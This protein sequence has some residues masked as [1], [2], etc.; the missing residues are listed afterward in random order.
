MNGAFNAKGNEYELYDA[1][2]KFPLYNYHFNREYYA[3][4]ANDLSG[5]ST[6]FYTEKK[7]FTRGERFFLIKDGES[8]W[9]VGGLGEGGETVDER[10]TVYKLHSTLLT[11]KRGGIVATA[12]GFVPLE[13][14]REFFIYTVKNEST[15]PKRIS[16]I[17]ACALEGGPMSSECLAEEGGR[18]ISVMTVPYHIYYEDYEKA[19]K[20]HNTCYC[21][22]SVQPSRV[23]CNE[24]VLF[25]GKRRYVKN[26]FD[27]PERTASYNGEH[28]GT[29]RYDAELQ[30]GESFTFSTVVGICISREDARKNVADFLSGKER[31]EDELKKA[32]AFFKRYASKKKTAAK[33]ENIDNFASFWQVKQV[34]CM[35]MTKRLSQT[36]S[37]RNSLQDAMGVGYV[38]REMAR[39]YFVECLKLQKSDGSILQHG[40]WNDLFPPR[41]LGLLYMKDGP[42]W[43]VICLSNYIYD[44]G[45]YDFLKQIVAFKDGGEDT[46]EG[47]LLR[48]VDFMWK[49]RGTYGLS[50]LG[51]GDWT[52]P[53]NGPGRKGKGVSTWTSMAFVYGMRTLAKVLKHEEKN[54]ERI[55]RKIDEMQENILRFC[56][57][58][59]RFIAGYND[60][61]VAY[62]CADD[63]EGSLFLNMH[64]WAILS[65]V[66][67]G[68]YLKRCIEVIDELTTPIGVLVMKPPFTRWNEKFGKISVKQEGKDE[69]G[70]VYCHAAAFAAYALFLSGEREKAESILKNILPTHEYKAQFEKQPPLFIPNY[71]FTKEPQYGESSALNSTGTSAWFLKIYHDFY[72]NTSAEN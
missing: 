36:Y 3:T 48:A 27:A 23:V 44:N 63:K 62:G 46:V 4:I 61:G 69:K 57:V 41:G 66:A 49:D 55:E 31:A 8:V 7:S 50:L 47:H 58:K 13:G 25:D 24:N 18:L 29:F 68:E 52:D 17:A 38:E 35:V 43:V 60:D 56:Y 30:P 37:I 20:E 72:E 21:A 32:E 64:S 11:A 67:K 65:G 28:I 53:I 70:S 14:A 5:E 15:Q 26:A 59:D 1:E 54:V 39:N 33:E 12:E 34:L 45:D 22:T 71:Y 9:S 6:C 19:M 42:S 10:T 40:V 51:D 2:T 16:I